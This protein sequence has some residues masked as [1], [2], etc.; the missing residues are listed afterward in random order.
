MG[1]LDDISGFSSSRRLKGYSKRSHL[2]ALRPAYTHI[3]LNSV[4]M[5][6]IYNFKQVIQ[7]LKSVMLISHAVFFKLLKICKNIMSVLALER[8]LVRREEIWVI[9]ETARKEGA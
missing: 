4:W 9:E 2:I 5:G 3:S 1:E 8:S 7:K 6:K